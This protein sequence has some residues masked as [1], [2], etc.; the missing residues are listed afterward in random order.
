MTSHP[1]YPYMSVAAGNIQAL[2]DG[3]HRADV[4]A[5]A[6]ADEFADAFISAETF[7]DDV[8]LEMADQL[9]RAHWVA[10]TR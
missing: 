4:A 2:L 3:W 9:A 1:E 6:T 8:N 5:H 10:T 7:D